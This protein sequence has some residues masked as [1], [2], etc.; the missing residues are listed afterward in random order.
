MQQ[1]ASTDHVT[2]ETG[3]CGMEITGGQG[4]GCILPR[5]A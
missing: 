1:P 4:E 3:I 5:M 2:G